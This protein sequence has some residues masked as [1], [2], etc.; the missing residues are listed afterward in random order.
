[1][2]WGRTQGEQTPAQPETVT[3]EFDWEGRTYRVRLKSVAWVPYYFAN[4]QVNE[5]S[6]LTDELTGD[7]V[8]IV[9]S[10]VGVVRKIA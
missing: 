10:K 6:L 2:P 8:M 1:M 9:W 5:V 7:E 3:V 4:Q